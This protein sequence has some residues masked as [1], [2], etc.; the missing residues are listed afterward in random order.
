MRQFCC[1]KGF[2]AGKFSV[3]SLR[4]ITATEVCFVDYGREVISA[5]DLGVLLMILTFLVER[6]FGNKKGKFSVT[7][8]MVYGD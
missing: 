3:L 1:L 4:E 2:W 7:G 5:S 6:G 8:C